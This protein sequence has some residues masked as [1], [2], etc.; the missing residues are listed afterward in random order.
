[1]K[2]FTAFFMALLMLGLS[3][4]A[5]QAE[6]LV[7]DK[8]AIREEGVLRIGVTQCPPFAEG[9]DDEWK[10]FD[11]A[12]A[13]AL[14]QELDLEPEFVELDWE[15]RWEAL[16]NRTVDCLMGCLSATDDLLGQADLTETYL[17][18]RPVLV[19]AAS[20]RDSNLNGAVIA[21]ESG[22]AG[23]MA[24]EI[25]LEGIEV[26]PVS[27]QLEALKRVAQGEAQAAVVDIL[28]AQEV[29][30]KWDLEILEQ[31]DLGVEEMSIA[32]RKGSDLTGELNR[33][34][35]ELQS[36]GKL[37]ALALEYGMAEELIQG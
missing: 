6:N 25:C 36:S 28:L 24:A 35:R 23:Q 26:E 3:A 8:E 17:A 7:A 29:L 31:P 5:K 33:V 11:I 19:T 12:L 22:S 32:L 30:E 20:A 9:K 10:G 4:C 1:M 34:L 21:V 16:G 13:E 15:N 27:S 37:E 2:H 14:C 18:S